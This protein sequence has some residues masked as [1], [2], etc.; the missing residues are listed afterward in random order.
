MVVGQPRLTQRLAAPVPSDEEQLLRKFL[1]D[2]AVARPRWGWKRAHEAAVKADWRVN[3]KRI[4]RLWRDEGLK[5][6]YRKRKKRLTG[7]GVVVGAMVPIAPDVIWALDF[8]FDQTSDGRTLKLLNVIDEFTRE[9]IEI[10]VERSITADDVMARLDE[11]S[12]T[13][14][15]P[16]FIRMD[17][18]AESSPIGHPC[19][20]APGQRPTTGALR[21]GA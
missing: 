3:R 1:R 10:K 9:T 2:F 8:Q 5:V 16:N 18:H 7:I 11:L 4:H 14:R 21:R 13:R 19:A 6:P 15:V 20:A 12:S 17:I